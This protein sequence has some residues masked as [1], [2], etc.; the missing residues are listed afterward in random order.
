MIHPEEPGEEAPVNRTL[1]GVA[2]WRFAAV[3]QRPID[4]DQRSQF[5]P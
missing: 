4:S 2:R 5:L 1:A 3:K